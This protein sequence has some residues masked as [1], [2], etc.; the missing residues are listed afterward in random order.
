MV[1]CSDHRAETILVWMRIIAVQS[2]TVGIKI[3]QNAS[4]KINIVKVVQSMIKDF[5]N[6]VKL[7]RGV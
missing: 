3:T 7:K 4:R 6:L 1:P 5:L 2:S